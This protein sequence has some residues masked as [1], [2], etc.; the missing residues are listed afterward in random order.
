[1]NRNII[2]LFMDMEG[3]L[4]SEETGK[5]NREDFEMLLDQINELQKETNAQVKI[6]LISPIQVE[7]MADILDRIDSYIGGYNF[8]T[9]GHIDD[10]QGATATFTRNISEENRKKVNGL[11]DSLLL[12]P[13]ILS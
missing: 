6:N 4:L 3:T 12:I 7:L 13:K 10:I 5:I 1:M 9:K 8:K 11:V 2:L